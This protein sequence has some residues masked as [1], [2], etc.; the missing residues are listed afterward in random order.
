[1]TLRRITTIA[2]TLALTVLST[3][4]AA[5]AHATIAAPAMGYGFAVGSATPAQFATFDK[6]MQYAS[7]TDARWVRVQLNWAQIEKTRGNDDW[8]TADAA[9]SSITSRGMT[10]LVL[11]MGT[12]G[13]AGGGPINT[14][15]PGDLSLF[16]AFASRVAQ[17]YSQVSHY[18]IWN[19]PNLSLF[20]GG[21]VNPARYTEM[22]KGA[23]TAIK[24]VR[25]GS[26]ST[27]LAA[28]L[29]PWSGGVDFVTKMYAAGA[30]GYFDAAAYHPYVFPRGIGSTPNG[31][32]ET[33]QIHALMTTN[34]DGGKKIWLTELGSPS[35]PTGGTAASGSSSGSLGSLFG[36][37]GAGGNA[38]TGG[39]GDIV[40]DQQQLEQVTSVLA[41][42]AATSWSG[43]AF[44]YTVHDSGTSTTDREQNFGV[45]RY[46]WTPKPLYT[47]LLR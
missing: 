7:R 18:E 41:A 9:I 20:W 25:P 45:L 39:A 17:R 19:E 31:W 38:P 22:L 37:A 23:Y 28:G 30:K 10:P 35:T 46:D 32:T 8:S 5:P 4:L 12:P 33:E 29:S 11:L 13:W 1:M 27:V 6:E 40:T 47:A 15:P 44:I 24:A 42:A 16:S 3:V 14:A 36:S 34:G 43:P 26:S 21:S 2:L